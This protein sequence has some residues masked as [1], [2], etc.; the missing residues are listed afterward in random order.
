MSTNSA[1]NSS[2]QL[3][4]IQRFSLKASS[5]SEDGVQK[6]T[7][8]MSQFKAS[9]EGKIDRAFLGK[10]SD[11]VVE[12]IFLLNAPI[13][14]AEAFFPFASS[15]EQLSVSTVVPNN[16]TSL[17]DA[18]HAPTT[19]TIVQD[20]VPGADL[21]AISEAWT[22]LGESIKSWSGGY[23]STF[24]FVQ[25]EGKTQ[26]VLINGWDEY[27]HAWKWLSTLDEANA[28]Y[29][30]SSVASLVGSSEPAFKHLTEIE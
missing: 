24:G 7:E 27:D 16:H 23:G 12:Q 6:L 2:A 4:T 3:V 25:Q 13:D 26:I 14:T 21:D 5:Q 18:I 20:L 1:V 17:Y 22:S 9:S 11:S 15:P 19:E 29:F 10:I 8:A 28:A 30:Q